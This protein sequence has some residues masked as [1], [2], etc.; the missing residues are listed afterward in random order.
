MSHLPKVRKIAGALDDPEAAAELLED[1]DLH[2]T[3]THV[4]E[5]PQERKALFGDVL[6]ALRWGAILALAAR[7]VRRLGRAPK[8]I[9]E[10]GQ[11]P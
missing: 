9:W 7:A 10:R 8:D 6:L 4:V 1:P 3:V 2:R 11:V 5:D